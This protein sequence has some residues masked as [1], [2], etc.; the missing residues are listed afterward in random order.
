[1]GIRQLAPCGPHHTMKLRNHRFCAWFSPS[2]TW[3]TEPKKTKATENARHTT[4]RRSDVNN[5]MTLLIIMSGPGFGKGD[6]RFL[7]RRHGPN[8]ALQF[9]KPEFAVPRHNRANQL[10]AV[11]GHVHQNRP[12]SGRIKGEHQASEVFFLHRA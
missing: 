2:S 6:E 9:V 5:L 12:G 8:I 7:L 10:L 3:A 11:V 4:V 1:M